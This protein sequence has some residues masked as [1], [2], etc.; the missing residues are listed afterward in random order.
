MNL[1]VILMAMYLIL[2]P[3]FLLTECDVLRHGIRQYSGHNCHLPDSKDQR[4]RHTASAAD[5]RSRVSASHCADVMLA[6]AGCTKFY[7]ICG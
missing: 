1:N 4:G 3:F 6:K 7:G 2:S 5:P